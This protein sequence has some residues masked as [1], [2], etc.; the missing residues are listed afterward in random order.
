[1]E[2]ITHLGPKLTEYLNNA[3]DHAFGFR[4]VGKYKYIGDT[5]VDFDNNNIIVEGKNMKVLMDY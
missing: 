5:K 1:M 3:N 4:P 2:K